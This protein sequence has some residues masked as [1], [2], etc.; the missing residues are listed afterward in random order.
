VKPGEC[1]YLGAHYHR[2]RWSMKSLLV[3]L[4]S[5]G[6]VRDDI[7]WYQTLSQEGKIFL[8]ERSEPLSV[9]EYRVFP[10]VCFRLYFLVASI[11]RRS[12]VVVTVRSISTCRLVSYG[13]MGAAQFVRLCFC[14]GCIRVFNHDR[15][16]FPILYASRELLLYVNGVGVLFDDVSGYTGRLTQRLSNN[17]IAA[18]P[19]W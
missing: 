11:P 4:S 14:L 3:L 12:A 16:I 10:I 17:V 2:A 7:R 6:I 18:Y 13:S 5:H 1:K 19:L 9:R 15:C 8:R